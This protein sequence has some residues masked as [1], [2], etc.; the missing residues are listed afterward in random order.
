MR[1]DGD[2]PEDDVNNPIRDPSESGGSPSM[3]S[4]DSP[5]SEVQLSFM[6]KSSAKPPPSGLEGYLFKKSPAL[7]SGWQKRYF[8]L[9]DPGEIDYY[10]TVASLSVLS[11]PH[12]SLFPRERNM[13]MASLPRVPSWWLRWLLTKVWQWS[14]EMK[15]GSTWALEPINSAPRMRLKPPHG[16]ALSMNGLAISP[17]MTE[18]GVLCVMSEG[19]SV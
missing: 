19:H 15:S 7:M 2:L 16:K 10:E 5:S 12:R 8:V 4:E 18:P 3:C 1:L 11:S 14:M 9:R 6:R 17:L 13:S